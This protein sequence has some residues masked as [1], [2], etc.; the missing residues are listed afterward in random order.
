MSFFFK[1]FDLRI[2]LILIRYVVDQQKRILWRI[3]QKAGNQF[4]LFLPVPHGLIARKKISPKHLDDFSFPHERQRHQ[5]S[6]QFCQLRFLSVNSNIVKNIIRSD[7]SFFLNRLHN[8]F[9][10]S[11]IFAIQGIGAAQLALIN[12]FF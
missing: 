1:R 11:L 10:K 8:F 3:F 2:F 4:D 6:F 5:R 9:N 12:L 7:P